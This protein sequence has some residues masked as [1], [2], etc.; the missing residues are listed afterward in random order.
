MTDQVTPAMTLCAML[1]L[2]LGWTPWRIAAAAVLT[3]AL[4]AAGVAAFAVPL[5]WRSAVAIGC[6]VGAAA[7]VIAVYFELR[8]GWWSALVAAAAAGLLVAAATSLAGR[9]MVLAETLPWV[10][11]CGPAA[12]LRWRGWTLATKVVA[13]WAMAIAVLSTGVAVVRPE[14]AAAG[15]H[16]D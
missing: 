2:L 12:L 3:L 5:E 16:L 15:D 8:L 13:S 6:W 4:T 11:L 7:I 9:A 14:A 10:L 1:G